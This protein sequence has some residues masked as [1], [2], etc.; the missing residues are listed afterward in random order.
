MGVDVIKIEKPGGDPARNMP[1]F[2]HDAPDPEKSLYWFG[3]NNNKRGITLDLETSQGQDS[4]KKL[5][6]K[7]DFVIESFLPGYMAELGLDYT[8]LADINHSIIMTSITPFG[9]SGP[10]SSFKAS[11]VVLQALGVLMNQ[12]GNPDRAPVRTTVPQAYLHAGADAAEGTMI[13]HYYRRLTGEGQYI[14]VSAMESVLFVAGRALPYWQASRTEI[15]RTAGLIS[16]TG[17]RFTPGIWECKDGY[18]GLLIHGGTMGART[19]KRL[20]EWMDS[21]QMAPSFMKERDWENWD[22]A[23]TTQT[24]L[25]SIQEAISRFLKNHT[26]EELAEES[27]KRGIQ[28][29]RVCNSAD[30]VANVQLKA[31]D[32]WV[33]IKHDELSDTITYPGAFAKFSLTP[34]TEWQ[35]APLIGEHN[36]DIL[37]KMSDLSETLSVKSEDINLPDATTPNLQKQALSGL[38]VVGFVTGGVGPIL[39]RSLA[40]HGATV[41]LIESIKQSNTNR[42]AGPFKDNKPGINRGYSFANVNSDKYSLCIDLKHPRAKEVTRRLASWADVFVDN[43]RTGV[44]ESWGLGYEDVKAIN[45]GIVMIGLSHEGHTGPHSREAGA[46]AILSALSGF[47][48]LTGWPDR[49]PVTL[50]AFGVL[51]DYIAPRFGN[52]ALLAALDYSKRTGKGQYIDLSEH[53][54]AIQFLMPAILDY[55]VNNRIQTRD[56]NRSPYAAPHGVYSCKGDDRW[57]AIAVFTDIEWEAFCKVIGN[58]EWTQET[59]FSTLAGRKENEDELDKL[60]EQWTVNH[61]AEEVM[62]IMQQ[63]GVEAGVVQGME[64]IVENCPQLDHRNYWW[65]LEHPEIGKTK[66]A[67]NSYILSKTPYQLQRPAPCF[68]EHT[69]YVCTQLLGMS[70]EEFVDLFQNDVFV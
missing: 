11:D 44:M 24:E 30:T 70:D 55:T 46:G 64:D 27:K 13:A 67:G 17:G 15:K 10:Y 6:K 37:G 19:N 26:R 51:P 54:A 48:H 52:A 2:Y 66:N 50:G 42:S 61:S 34:T 60:V 29:D 62:M 39:V 58:P 25:D 53:E 22:W 33:N 65:M 18:V 40:T 59:K 68:G 41:V 57:C 12:Q 5:V 43:W 4:F 56:G 1:P 35:R 20:T 63:A 69:G 49:A 21:E 38:K 28:L 47:I 23:Q 31:R 45:P 3:Y 16:T 8:N 36:D 9:Q 14:D 32:F 7:S